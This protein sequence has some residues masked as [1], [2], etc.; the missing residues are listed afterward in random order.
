MPKHKVVVISIA[1]PILIGI[2]NDKNE[3]V[4]T[5]EQIGKTSDILP[6]AFSTILNKYSINEIFY[7]NGPGSFMAIK[8]AY[9]FL[10]TLTITNDIS[11]KSCDGFHFN[12]NSPIKALAKKYFFK[13]E[14]GK[15]YIDFLKEEKIKEFK[16]PQV[17]NQNIFSEE[18]LPA[19]HLPAVN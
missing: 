6:T 15:I 10:K 9:I 13:D 7:V 3:L 17:L 5:I 19:Y 8:V 16:L 4:E 18:N 12:D 2:Y 11:L 14:N 1:N